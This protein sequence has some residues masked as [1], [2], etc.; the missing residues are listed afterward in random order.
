[1]TLR[2]VSFLQGTQA[3]PYKLPAED[4]RL[5][6]AGL[7]LPDTAKGPLGVRSGVVWG[8]GTPGGVTVV[9]GGLQV[10]PFHAVIQGTVNGVQ[11]PYEVTSDATEFRAVTA[12][13]ST[14]F[15]RGYLVAR[16]RDQISAADTTDDWT[17]FPEYGAPAATAGAAQLPNVP[18]NSVVLREFAVSN[19]GVITLAG[20]TPRTGPRHGILPVDPADTTLPSYDGQ[21]RDHP[22]RGLERGAAGAWTPPGLGPDTP[23]FRGL[24]TINQIIGSSAFTTIVLN[25]IPAAT[26]GFTWNGTAAVVPRWGW[27][28]VQVSAGIV[29]PSGGRL[30][31]VLNKNGAPTTIGGSTPMGN[32]ADP[33]AKGAGLIQ[34]GTGDALSLSV[35]QDSGANR[36]VNGAA[37]SPVALDAIW[38]R[39][40]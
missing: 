40:L 6:H 9:A 16:V 13:S 30:L 23:L 19:T 35:Y 25:N 12:A 17:I 26:G 21:Y 24:R 34:L 3:A 29:Q 14:E 11:G 15:R 38:L 4:H 8:P 20:R 27:Y 2:K 18:P 31:A 33:S 32:V 37:W 39:P 5:N 36:D 10:A 1:M 28:W 22:T 7:W